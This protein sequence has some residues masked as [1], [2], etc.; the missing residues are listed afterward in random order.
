M[1]EIKKRGRKPLTPEQKALSAEKRKEYDAKWK[2][3]HGYAAQKKYQA[4]HKDARKRYPINIP[5][6]KR[7]RFEELVSKSGMTTSEFIISVIEE[8]YGTL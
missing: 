4:S 7:A 1:E 8:K 2:K 3:E 6:D 5:I